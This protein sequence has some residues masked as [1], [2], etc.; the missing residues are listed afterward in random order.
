MR[1][2]KEKLK[3]YLKSHKLMSLATFSGKPWIS[4]VYYAIDANLSLYFV[5]EPGTR[6]CKDLLL[7]PKVACSITDSGQK[8]TDKKVGVQIEGIASLVTHKE[9]TKLALR[10]WNKANQ[11]VKSVI[12]F[13]N[14]QNGTIKSRVFKIEPQV[15][16]FF[17][18][19]LYGPEGFEIF[20]I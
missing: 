2:N 6:H 9:Q 8:A 13:E 17:N 16:K 1:E 7:N 10:L 5:S 3:K 20:N 19:K 11:G 4:V 18:E 12:N 15:I 14:M